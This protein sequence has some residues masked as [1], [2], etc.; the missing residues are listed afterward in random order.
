MTCP[1]CFAGVRA[2]L[3]ILSLPLVALVALVA[4]F[5]KQYFDGR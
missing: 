1:G 5:S 4:Y 3:A 2:L